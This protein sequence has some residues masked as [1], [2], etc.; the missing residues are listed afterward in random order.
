M[1]ELDPRLRQ[2]GIDLGRFELC[3][4]LLMNDR[5]YPWFILVPERPR[6][7]EIYQ[8]TERDQMRL[9]R[10]SSA[11]AAAMAAVFR[12]HKLNIAAIGNL[13]RQLHVHHIARGVDD[14]AWP[15]VVWGRT[16]G[17]PYAPGEIEWITDE[18]SRTLS[19]RIDL[20]RNAAL[21]QE[22]EGPE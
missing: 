12:P 13:V 20:R 9:M 3:R 8:L 21:G 2:D 10:E 14:P 4:L 19:G 1:F 7:T 15:G 11:L 16:P 5:S 22:P 6:V 17:A 18:I